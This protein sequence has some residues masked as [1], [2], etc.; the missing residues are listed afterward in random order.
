[1]DG[2]KEILSF[3]GAV[4]GL[5]SALIPLLGYLADKRR[6]ASGLAEARTDVSRAVPEHPPG[7]ASPAQPLGSNRTPPVSRA[8]FQKAEQ[9]VRT[10]AI[11]M[12]VVGALSLTTNLATAGIGLIDEFVVP[13]GIKPA[14]DNPMQGP[15][16]GQFD[17]PGLQQEA[18][19]SD[20]G[21]TVLGIIGILFFSLA[22]AVAIWSG[23]NMLKLRNYWLALAGS[24]AL[25]PGSCMCCL[26]GLPSGIWSL[27]VL[28]NPE[29]KAAFQSQ[30]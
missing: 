24:V 17:D 19:G 1:M 4:F 23:Y 10:P 7:N 30:S 20:R 8:A 22:S 16:R 18:P 9:L 11:F 5:I 27:V 15:P 12:I 21:T 29:V 6:R 13:L 28:L 2:L 25:M 14:R 3:L 26:L